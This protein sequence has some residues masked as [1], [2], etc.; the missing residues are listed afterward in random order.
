M[1]I[2]YDSSTCFTLTGKTIEPK[3]IEEFDSVFGIKVLYLKD[4]PELTQ[5]VKINSTPCKISGR[6]EYQACKD[7]CIPLDTTFVFVREK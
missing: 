6:I 3:Q 5:K 2:T 1:V 7:A 4:K